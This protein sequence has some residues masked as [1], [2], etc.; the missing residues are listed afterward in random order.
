[1]ANQKFLEF[2][3]EFENLY[4]N[5][6][7]FIRKSVFQEKENLKGELEVYMFVHAHVLYQL[8]K[9]YPN[10]DELLQSSQLKIMKTCISYGITDKQFIVSRLQ[11]YEKQLIIFYKTGNFEEINKMS[12][13]FHVAPLSDE[14]IYDLHFMRVEM[15]RVQ[16]VALLNSLKKETILHMFKIRI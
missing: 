8:G 13:A 16:L 6:H 11:F 7:K 10:L 2:K 14:L 1:M 12:F 15:V 4:Y 5:L 3:D 9:S